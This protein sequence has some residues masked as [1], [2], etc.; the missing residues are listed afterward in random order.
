MIKRCIVFSAAGLALFAMLLIFQ[1]HSQ[2]QYEFPLGTTDSFN[3]SMNDSEYDKGME[4][5]QRKRL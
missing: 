2:S 3:L 1:Y 5:Q 4:G